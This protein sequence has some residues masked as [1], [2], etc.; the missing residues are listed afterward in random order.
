MKKLL[1]IMVLGL[2]WSG[3]VYA[4][5]IRMECARH[6]IYT[7]DIDRM[8][9]TS[10]R[11]FLKKKGSKELRAKPRITV[12]PI[13]KYNNELIITD[14]ANVGG[15]SF[16]GQANSLLFNL[17]D[18]KVSGDG[19][20]TSVETM[21]KYNYWEKYRKSDLELHYTYGPFNCP[22][23]NTL[24]KASSNNNNAKT[25]DIKKTCLSFGYKEG[26]EKFA[27]CMKDLYLKK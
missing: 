16:G 18:K 25:T 27:D 14:Y 5:P 15:G 23:L 9:V 13:K 21:N 2:L 7:V 12:Y 22:G 6:L 17:K 1:M 11:Y 26:T 3:N 4:E 19:F 8:T 24:K 20:K 10:E